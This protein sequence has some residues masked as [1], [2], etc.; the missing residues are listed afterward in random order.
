M[1]RHERVG[2]GGDGG[3]M[4]DR[5]GVGVDGGGGRGGG[6]DGWG[7]RGWGG[8][9]RIKYNEYRLSMLMGNCLVL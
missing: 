6:L 7:E 1:R 2:G 3:R 9:C 4:R 5:V 8:G